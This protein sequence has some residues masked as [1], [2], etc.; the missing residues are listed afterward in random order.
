MTE[1]GLKTIN[2]FLFIFLQTFFL[3]FFTFFTL[4][5]VFFYFSGMF[6]Y[7][8]GAKYVVRKGSYKLFC[9]LKYNYN[10]NYIQLPQPTVSELILEWGV[11]E[12]RPEVPRAGDGV[13]REATASPSPP[14]RGFAVAL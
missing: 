2:V 5:K 9:F 4:L 13:F 1:R 3:L 10:C 11:G 8:Y 7:I 14:T 12:A 6:F